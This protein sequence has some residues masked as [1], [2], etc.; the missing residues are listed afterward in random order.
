MKVCELIELLQR[1]PN[2]NASVMYDMKNALENRDLVISHYAVEEEE[3]ENHFSVED[4]LVGT[5]T[6]KGFV[7]LAEDELTD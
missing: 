2:Q 6:L 1:C 7:F 5:G 4:V 3:T